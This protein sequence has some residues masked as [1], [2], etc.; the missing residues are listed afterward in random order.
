MSRVQPVP[1]RAA[2][3][4]PLVGFI[5]L[6]TAVLGPL[7]APGYLLLLDAPAGPN[8]PWQ[9]FFPL[10]SSGLV[11]SAAPAL[12][13]LRAVGLIH[14][15]LPNKLLIAATVI[16]GGYGL[17]R[18]LRRDLELDV[19]PSLVGGVFFVVNPWVYERMLA[20]QILLTLSCAMLPFA[21]P[22]L[23]RVTRHGRRADALRALGWMGVIAIV[24]VHGGAMALLLTVMAIA[25]SPASLIRRALLVLGSLALFAAIGLYWILPSLVAEEGARLGA[26]DY[27]AYSPRPRSA[28]ILPHV[29]MLHGYWRLEFPTPLQ[30][31]GAAFLIPFLVLAAAAIAGLLWAVGEDRYRRAASALAT[32]CLVAVVLGMGRSFPPTEP[33][34]R[35]MFERVPGYGIFREPQ[36]W[37]AVLALGYG[38][39][40]GVGLQMLSSALRRLHTGARPVVAAAVV[41]PLVA[42]STI[43]WGF[44]GRVS[45]SHFPDGWQRAEEITRSKDGS[46]LAMPWNLYQPMRLTGGR[47]VANPMSH[48]FSSEV[49]VSGDAR[50]FVRNETPPPDPRDTF[51][52]ALIRGRRAIDRMGAFLAPMGVRWVALVHDAD[53]PFYRFLFRQQDLSVAFEDDDITLFENKSFEG[54]IYGL[55]SGRTASSIG[56]VL[57][58]DPAG[59]EE[60]TRIDP[61]FRSAVLPGLSSERSWP[62]WD[63]ID[64]PDAPVVGTSRS[65]LD[66]WRLG[67]QE[68]ECHLGAFAAFPDSQGSTLWRR[69]LLVQVIA[70][71]LS[72]AALLGLVVAIRRAPRPADGREEPPG[73]AGGSRSPSA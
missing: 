25:F 33:V 39:F 59:T 36:K 51:V 38:V 2:R 22:S 20:G 16:V 6:G 69:G 43:L 29:F 63:A 34:A 28:S 58:D 8:A 60:L 26:G 71:A 72:A 1:S 11:T 55:E 14:P 70:I 27:I 9:S 53:W 19:W 24:D 45:L 49:L 41:L 17:Y 46:I 40:A 73:P 42:S 44:G 54:D 56:E 47:F 65:C 57:R 5:A 3:Y 32:S 52:D 23:W 7:I 67:D 10:P 68:A 15:Q 12:N 37:I 21:L 18:F 50:L 61:S 62:W 13:V 66:G 31:N 64:T 4:L 35:F 48:Y 30:V